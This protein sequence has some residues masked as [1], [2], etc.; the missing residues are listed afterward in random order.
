MGRAIAIII[1]AALIIANLS[2]KEMRRIQIRSMGKKGDKRP[3]ATE[4]R[5]HLELWAG[6]EN[7]LMNKSPVVKI[8][9]SFGDIELKAMW[10]RQPLSWYMIIDEPGY[11]E[12]TENILDC[13][14]ECGIYI[15]ASNVILD[16]KGHTLD[17]VYNETSKYGIYVYH[18][19]NVTIR[20][21]MI[22]EWY[23]HGVLLNTSSGVVI[24]DSIIQYNGYGVTEYYC[25][26][27]TIANNTISDNVYSGVLIDSAS[28]S[29]ILNNTISNNQHHGA[30]LCLYSENSMVM[31]NLIEGNQYAGIAISGKLNIITNNTILG[32]GWSGI[33]L[34][35]SNNIVANNTIKRNT[36][37]GVYLWYCSNNT[38]ASNIMEGNGYPEVALTS[39][40]ENTIMDNILRRSNVGGIYLE[41]ESSGNVIINNTIYTCLFYGVYLIQSPANIIENNTIH[42]NRRYGICLTN[43]SSNTTIEGNTL[44]ENGFWEI[45]L[46]NVSN[47]VIIRNHILS[48]ETGITLFTSA[49]NNTIIY[50]TIEH[51]R[52]YGIYIYDS[53]NNTIYLNNFIENMEQYYVYEGSPN[54]FYSRKKITY[55]YLGDSYTNYGGNYWSDHEGNDINGDGIVDEAYGPDMYPLIYPVA[56][57]NGKI[58]IDTP[59]T[60]EIMW[61]AREEILNQATIILRWNT[62]DFENDIDHHEIYVDGNLVNG[63]IPA[64]QTSYVL[65]LSE[66]MHNI[67]IRTMDMSRNMD[68]DTIEITIDTTPP[69]III[70]YPQNGEVITTPIITIEWDGDDE[71]SGIDHF[72]IYV[73]GSPINTSI[74]VSQT[75][76]TLELTEGTHN[77]TIMAVDKAGNIGTDSIIVEIIATVTPTTTATRGTGFRLVYLV[78]LGAFAITF[79]VIVL[80]LVRRRERWAI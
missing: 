48:G 54:R 24:A 5:E 33:C 20:N 32:N 8:K 75:N 25:S 35:N 72:E 66:G 45:K 47:N 26:N 64:S 23:S 51:C 12:L 68:E 50:N 53:Q 31:R 41:E 46:E 62:T 21:I 63:S 69:S 40:N 11:Y 61:P 22:K 42:N 10:G 4:I 6:T 9:K 36:M 37:N 56:I 27:N 60:T 59:P 52:G 78:L 77:I 1:L 76:Y 74:P 17:G 49:S 28:T 71:V 15:N 34:W 65:T 67:T 2:N 43:Y 29:K 44:K 38:I 39:S 80:I 58:T 14:K 13:T 79:A 16:G 18:A 30:F 57:I 70:S 55:F 3:W 73:D 19:T 7:I